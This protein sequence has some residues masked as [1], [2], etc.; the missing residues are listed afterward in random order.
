MFKFSRSK[1]KAFETP[2]SGENEKFWLRQQMLHYSYNLIIV[3]L[4]SSFIFF[5]I[6]LVGKGVEGEIDWIIKLFGNESSVKNATP[7]IF[8][9]IVGLLVII[10]ARDKTRFKKS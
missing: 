5:G 9:I 4:G 2:V 7:G 6:R 1:N 8:L 3:L 10:F